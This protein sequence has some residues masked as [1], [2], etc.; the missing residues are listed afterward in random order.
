MQY[1]SRPEAK[2]RQ[3]T[4]SVTNMHAAL[5]LQSS[6]LMRATISSGRSPMSAAMRKP[7]S[8]RKANSA[9]GMLLP[10]ASPTAK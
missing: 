1:S 7:A 9:A 6:E 3:P 5:S 2:S 4:K 8:A 10:D